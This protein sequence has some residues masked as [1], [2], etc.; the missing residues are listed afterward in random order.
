[1]EQTFKPIRESNMLRIALL[2]LALAA[3][4]GPEPER[5]VGPGDPSQ[6]LDLSREAIRDVLE[7]EGT[8]MKDPDASL[9]NM[10]ADQAEEK[11]TKLSG[12]VLTKEEAED[13]RSAVDGVQVELEVPPR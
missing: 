2:V 5:E 1:M 7:E 12:K 3:C 6:E 10:F 11:Q 9:P 8:V 13:L 4:S